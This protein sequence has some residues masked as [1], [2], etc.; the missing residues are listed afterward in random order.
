[1]LTFNYGFWEFWEEYNPGDYYGGQK[2]TF[3]GENRIIYV[4]EGVTFLDVKTDIYSNWKEWMS[5]RPTQDQPNSKWLVAISAIGGEALSDVA[6]AGSTFF[7]ENQWR[8]KP[9]ESAEGYVL[10][11]NGNIY[12]REVGDNPIVPTSGVS[13]SLTRSNLVDAIVLGGIDTIPDEVKDDI[14][15]RVWE[16]IDGNTTLT[17]EQLLDK[18]DVNTE[19]ALKKGEF[20]ALK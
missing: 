13:V 10:T 20:L 19:D 3:D 4:N 17:F 12:T 5:V 14:A 8:I 2:V 11:I 16:Q 15:R 6:Y 1:M 7:L 18:I 9:Y